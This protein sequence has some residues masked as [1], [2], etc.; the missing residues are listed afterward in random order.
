MTKADEVKKKKIQ[1]A[2]VKI[3]EEKAAL[4]ESVLNAK[5]MK[6]DMA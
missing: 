1:K 3:K 4:E 6:K 5:F 2:E